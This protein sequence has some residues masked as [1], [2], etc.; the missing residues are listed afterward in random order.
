MMRGHNLRVISGSRKGHKLK[1]PQGRLIRPTEDRIKESFFNILGEISSASL[2]LDLFSGSGSI[3]IEFLS[4]GANKSY[5]VDISVV[6]ISTIKE[7][8]RRTRFIDKAIVIKKDAIQALKHF[9]QQGLVFDYIYLDPPYR[10]HT[11][12]LKVL[13]FI[14]C[15]SMLAD[16]GMVI[17]EH[18]KEILLDDYLYGFIKKDARKYGKKSLAFYL[19]KQSG[20]QNNESNISR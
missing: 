14:Y 19:V 16:K 12:L 3:G 1:S 20:G 11:L 2:V 4:R 9:K 6:S 13:E 10:E 17:V 8:L 5:F 7:N 18:E 15:N